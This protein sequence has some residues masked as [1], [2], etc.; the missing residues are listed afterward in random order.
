MLN[1][2]MT[3]F[4]CIATFA[5]VV[6]IISAIMLVVGLKR[7]DVKLKGKSLLFRVL[8]S[9]VFA[10]GGIGWVICWIISL[11]VR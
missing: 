11:F 10:V 6:W 7:E 3:I 8:S 9:R 5:A 4:G 2:L 1:V